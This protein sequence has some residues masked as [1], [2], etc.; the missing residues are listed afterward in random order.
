[1]KIKHIIL[2]FLVGGT[3]LSHAE[4]RVGDSGAVTIGFEASVISTDNVNSD[5][6]ED[7]DVITSVLPTLQYKSDAGATSIE[8]YVGL[9][10]ITYNDLSENDSEDF[11]SNLKIT[12][13]DELDGE[14][15][16]LVIEGGYNELTSARS[17]QGGQGGVVSTEE[18]DI[19]LNTSYYITEDITLRAAVEHLDK[20]SLTTGF[21]DLT[22]MTVPVAFYYDIDESLSTGIGYRNRRS[23][24]GNQ[25][26]S[27]KADSD[28][29]AFF[30]G[31][32]N[33]VSDIWGY[34][35]EVGIQERDFDVDDISDEDGLFAS[36]LVNWQVSDMTEVVGELSN[37]FGTTLAN[38]SAEIASAGLQLNHTFDERLS[39]SLGLTY[40]EIEYTQASGARDDDRLSSFLTVDYKL[41]DGQWTL[42]GSVGHDDNDSSV[43]PANYQA[44]RVGL[45]SIYVF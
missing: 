14:N 12:F 34:E 38:Q 18:V 16:S 21:A 2:L 13:P 43:A 26:T 28:D 1:M 45:S 10:F 8:A 36:F 19:S 20:E 35:L 31:I 7:S 5:S 44:L 42:R 4:F 25:V 29:E 33:Q 23:K 3:S 15:F 24:V 6:T 27:A 41:I 9:E 37:E 32:E 17:N 30:V 40:V 39:A 11:K 22:T